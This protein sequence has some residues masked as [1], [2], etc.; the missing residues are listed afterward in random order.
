MINMCD[1]SFWR[2]DMTVIVSSINLTKKSQ[3]LDCLSLPHNKSLRILPPIVFSYIQNFGW[4]EL[5]IQEYSPPITAKSKDVVEGVP[6]IQAYSICHSH[7]N[8]S[9]NFSRA[10]SVRHSPLQIFTLVNHLSFCT[11]LLC[12]PTISV[13]SLSN[14]I[15]DKKSYHVI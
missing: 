7:F 8:S 4:Y 9:L 1:N 12:L 10:S 13:S 15:Y 14:L 11:S 2:P 3:P 5:V 6:F